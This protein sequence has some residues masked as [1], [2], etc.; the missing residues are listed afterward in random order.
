MNLKCFAFLLVLLTGLAG[1]KKHSCKDTVCGLNE[2]CIE[3]LCQHADACGINRHTENGTCVCNSGWFG[4]NCDKQTSIC[5]PHSHSIENWCECD[6]GWVGPNCDVPISEFIGLY[7]VTG[8]SSSWHGNQ[9]SETN[10]DQLLEVTLRDDTLKLYGRNHLYD[11]DD[12][13]RYVFRWENTSNVYSFISFSKNINDSMIYY[14]Q[15][16]SLG[17]AAYVNLTGVK[18]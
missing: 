14:S 4:W 8:K 15:S 9:G 1:C 10:I 12:T 3:G 6:S 17:G 7:H 18:Q 2:T 13:A 16:V 11:S 5:G